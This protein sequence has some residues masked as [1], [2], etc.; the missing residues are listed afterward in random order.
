[1]LGGFEMGGVD[2]KGERFYPVAHWSHP[3]VRTYIKQRNIPLPPDYRMFGGR[4]NFQDIDPES[5]AALKVSY[6][7]DYEKI[8]RLYPFVHA[9]DARMKFFGRGGRSGRRAKHVG[10]GNTGG[11]RPEGR[12]DEVR[13]VPDGGDAAVGPETVSV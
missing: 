9:Q 7:D 1:M 13:A 12:P 11:D 3:T 4:Q 10:D 2:T 6:P 8:V 5:L